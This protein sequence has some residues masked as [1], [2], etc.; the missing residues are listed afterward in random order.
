MRGSIQEAGVLVRIYWPQTLLDLSRRDIRDGGKRQLPRQGSLRRDLHPLIQPDNRTCHHSVDCYEPSIL[1]LGVACYDA[2]RKLLRVSSTRGALTKS[3][4]RR[5]IV[6][7]LTLSLTGV[8][9]FLE[10]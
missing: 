2:A 9:I 3:L 8:F 1:P 6:A 4:L 10:G 5:N 7:V